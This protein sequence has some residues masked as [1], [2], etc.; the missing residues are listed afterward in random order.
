ML[1]D[2]SACLDRAAVHLEVWAEEHTDPS[3]I[4]YAALELRLALEAYIFDRYEAVAGEPPETA[5]LHPDILFLELAKFHEEAMTPQTWSLSGIVE[6]TRGNRATAISLGYTLLKL[7]KAR[8]YYTQLNEL[9]HA[10]LKYESRSSLPAYWEKE[11]AFLQKVHAD[12]TDLSKGQMR[13]PDSPSAV[14]SP[15]DAQAGVL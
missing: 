7:E 1:W 11:A 3:V 15:G 12:L 10:G 2:V 9:L 6:D 4:R 13:K 8:D 14:Q 5:S